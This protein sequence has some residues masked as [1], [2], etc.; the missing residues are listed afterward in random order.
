MHVV[1]SLA[2]SFLEVIL[3]EQSTTGVSLESDSGEI[4]LVIRVTESR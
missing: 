3:P 1:H 2:T 4:L